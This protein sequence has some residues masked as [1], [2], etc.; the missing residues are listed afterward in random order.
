MK[1][2]CPSCH[3]PLHVTTIGPELSTELHC[4]GCNATVGV[5]IAMTL[6]DAG[7]APPD[8]NIHRS[9]VLAV[10]DPE[11]RAAYSSRL[12]TAGWNVRECSEGRET[13]KTMANEVP[14]VAVIDGGFAPIFGM[15]LGEIIKKS[16]ITRSARILGLR[17]DNDSQLPLPGADRTIAL[18]AGVDA[19]LNAVTHLAPN[20]GATRERPN[21]TTGTI[22]KPLPAETFENAFLTEELISTPVPD[23]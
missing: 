21:R 23:I 9:V 3:R 16:N 18:T 10:A 17:A 2:A 1:L 22:S 20:G 15:R 7:T 12:K 19:L 14:D 13:L 8:A 5:T 4:E 11:L 6:L